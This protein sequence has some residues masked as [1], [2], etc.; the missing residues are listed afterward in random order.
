[1]QY[2]LYNLNLK[3]IQS[4]L[5][6]LL[7]AV[8]EAKTWYALLIVIWNTAGSI[9]ISIAIILLLGGG[10]QPHF[11]PF[12]NPDFD[13]S[14]AKM[15]KKYMER[16]E[17]V[18]VLTHCRHIIIIV[19]C[20]LSL[21]FRVTFCITRLWLLAANVLNVSPVIWISVLLTKMIGRYRWP[22]HMP[23]TSACV[24]QSGLKSL[25]NILYL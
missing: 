12:P 18:F 3:A 20:I 17:K 22:T 23:T 14:W 25:S 16:G 15:G 7:S 13:V 24:C 1:M 11:C 2:T 19:F 4:D 10:V 21:I 6:S 5:Y 8:F 9:T